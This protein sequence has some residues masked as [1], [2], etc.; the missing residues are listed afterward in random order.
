[1]KCGNGLMKFRIEIEIE[2]LECDSEKRQRAVSSGMFSITK[3][4]S[5]VRIIFL[6]LAIG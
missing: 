3:L 6:H 5:L 2:R 1:M 4:T